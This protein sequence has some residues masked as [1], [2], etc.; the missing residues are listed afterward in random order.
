MGYS[1]G[2]PRLRR[3][4]TP[5]VVALLRVS[6]AVRL[7]HARLWLHEGIA[8]EIVTLQDIPHGIRWRHELG[9]AGMEQSHTSDD[10][11]HR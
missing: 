10:R 6:P 5:R 1:A 8:G 9:P 4:L 3:R 7:A 2:T 11:E